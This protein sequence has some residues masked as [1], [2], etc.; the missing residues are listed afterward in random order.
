MGLIYFTSSLQVD[1]N[2]LNKV[3]DFLKEVMYY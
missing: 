3:L 2:K 1:E